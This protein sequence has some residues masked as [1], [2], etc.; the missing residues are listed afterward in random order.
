MHMMSLIGQ[1]LG[2][3]SLRTFARNSPFSFQRNTR[4]FHVSSSSSTSSPPADGNGHRSGAASVP[5]LDNTWS[6]ELWRPTWASFDDADYPNKCQSLEDFRR[7]SALVIQ[8]TE[9]LRAEP[10]NAYT[11]NRRASELLRLGYPE[12]AAGDAFRSKAHVDVMMRGLMEKRDQMS[13]LKGKEST[14][15]MLRWHFEAYKGLMSALS[16]TSDC[17][18]L[19]KICEEGAQRYQ[20]IRQIEHIVPSMTFFKEIKE[21][22]TVRSERRQKSIEQRLCSQNEA[23]IKLEYGVISHQAYAFTPEKYVN[24]GT[25]VIES[26]KSLFHET[27]SSC[28][29]DYSPV[30]LPPNSLEEKSSKSLGVF[31]TRDIHFAELVVEDTTTIA[32]SAVSAAAPSTL[33]SNPNSSRI[34]DNCYGS[35]PRQSSEHVLSDCCSTPYC[36]ARCRDMALASYHKVL[37]GQ[38]FDWLYEESNGKLEPF[39]LNGPLWLRILAACVQS[40]CHPL[41]HP[42]IAR[43]APLHEKLSRIW[44][45]SNN[46]VT[47]FKILRQLGVDPTDDFRYDTWVLQTIWT[48]VINNQ[49]EHT[50]PDGRQV[51]AISPLYSFFNHS[52]EPNTGW[53]PTDTP[54][55]TNGSA[56]DIFAKRHIRKG[57]ELCIDY[58][59]FSKNE[60]KAERQRVIQSWIGSDKECG[61]T[62]C[63]RG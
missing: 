16:V 13:F 62:K 46:I 39:V 37:C 17:K 29:L 53:S 20:G 5:S 32:A 38:N 22:V 40:N 59:N 27:S 44:A 41:D 2:L 63:Q 8:L 11:L 48:R 12:L 24:R 36:T 6:F 35:I 60:N 19:L 45:L 9:E 25:D 50:T 43:L 10:H 15:C 55:C 58:V 56:K 42:S 52:C 28:R 4:L 51:R 18:S 31:A 26:A 30:G 7:S 14:E 47:P 21:Y 34:C 57:E 54:T 33:K 23:Q 49:E 3:G 1:P 61:C